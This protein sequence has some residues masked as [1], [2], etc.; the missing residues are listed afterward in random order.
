MTAIMYQNAF[1]YNSIMRMLHGSFED[2][3]IIASMVEGNSVLDLACATCR[4]Q[5]FLPQ[6][7]KYEGW[8]LNDRFI[9][10]CKKNGITVKKK[11]VFGIGKEKKKWNTIII[12]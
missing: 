5:K 2:Y 6:N 10:Y 4:I 1:L 7:T 9:S 8:E 3:K 11:N 12:K